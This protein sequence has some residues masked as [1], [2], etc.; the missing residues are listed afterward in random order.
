MQG[1]N[2]DSL[3]KCIWT[4]KIIIFAGD[5]SHFIEP[6]N[7]L[8]TFKGIKKWNELN[9]TA[10]PVPFNVLEDVA[11]VVSGGDLEGQSSVMALKHSCVIVEDGQL[12]SCIAQEA[13]GATWVVHVMHSSSNKSGHLINGIQTLLLGGG[14]DK[15][16]WKIKINMWAVVTAVML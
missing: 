6:N 15:R 7:F 10:S 3:F 9:V 2:I 11:L 13:V 8:F 4:M 14:G 1:K 12:T 16:E 5:R